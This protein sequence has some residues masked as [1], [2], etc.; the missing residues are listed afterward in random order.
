MDAITRL[1][2]AAEAK[3]RFEAGESYESIARGFEVSAR[4]VRR[5][6]KGETKPRKRRQPY[7]IPKDWPEERLWPNWTAAQLGEK[8]GWSMDVAEANIALVHLALDQGNFYIPWYMRRSGEVGE[9]YRKEHQQELTRNPWL[10]A[11]VGLPVLAAWMDCPACNELARLI[12][13]HRPWETRE[14]RRAYETSAEPVASLVKACAVQA[15]ARAVLSA[16]M[17]GTDLSTAKALPIVLRALIQRVP[18]FDRRRR[19]SLYGLLFSRY[20][21]GDIFLTIVTWPTGGQL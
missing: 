19:L 21:V 6:V 18:M 17:K 7:D 9:R 15:G 5:W 2:K 14:Q 4:T 16:N 20:S 11:V 3:Q 8:V 13:D 12:E 1:D 10:Q